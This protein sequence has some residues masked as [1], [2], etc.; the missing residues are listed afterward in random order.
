MTK[1]KCIGYILRIEYPGCNKRKGYF[2]PY[3]TGEFSKYPE[4]WKPVYEKNQHV[5]WWTNMA[6][7]ELAHAQLGSMDAPNF[8]E[9]IK[10]QLD[11]RMGRNGRGRLWV[12]ESIDVTAM[13]NWNGTHKNAD[14]CEHSAGIVINA[15]DYNFVKKLPGLVTDLVMD[16]YE[17]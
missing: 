17:A 6:D 5:I 13:D 8:P 14:Y 16:T 3:T 11:D 7:A 2:E 1:R 12:H 9:Y 15:S 10:E 4:I